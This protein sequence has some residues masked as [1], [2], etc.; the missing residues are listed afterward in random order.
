MFHPTSDA[1]PHFIG[2]YKNSFFFPEANG[3]IPDPMQP[4]WSCWSKRWGPIGA[5]TQTS[6]LGLL[7]KGGAGKIGKNLVRG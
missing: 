2:K 7:G 4:S 5:S 6:F 3:D 1:L